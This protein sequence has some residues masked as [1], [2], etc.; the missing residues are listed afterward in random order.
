MLSVGMGLG[1]IVLFRRFF[2]RQGRLGYFLSRQAYTVYITHI[3]VIVLLALAL[4][5]LHPEA[6]LKVGLAAVIGIPLCFGVA[7]LVRRI[8]LASRIL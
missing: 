1:L 7:Y 6:L 4:R 2:D 8:P 5:G 3:T